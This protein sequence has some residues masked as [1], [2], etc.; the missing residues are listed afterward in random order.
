MI[1]RILP[2]RV[3]SAYLRDFTAAPPPSPAEQA[4]LGRAGSAR[5]LEFAAGRHCA[6]TALA[7]LGVADGEV[8]RGADRAPR[9]PAG[10]L[11]AI[12]H[13]AGYGAA[14]VGTTA[15]YAA[16][17]IDAEPN[18]TLPSLV[19]ERITNDSERRLLRSAPAR[20]V[21]WD[22]LLFSAKESVYKAWA[23]LTGT[24]LGFLDVTLTIE[25]D[26][27]R[28]HAAFH[29]PGPLVG[30]IRMTGF[31]G[32]FLALPGLLLT[33]IVIPREETP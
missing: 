24:W 2:D 29:V 27:G 26:R 22:R 12:T 30:G 7:A 9:W 18:D 11:G 33:A 14:A 3:A 23:P 25:P 8:P 15:R 6:R 17:G 16:I 31:S 10:T 13:C 20:G 5:T 4:G 21:H 1:G 32:R 28:F 19:A